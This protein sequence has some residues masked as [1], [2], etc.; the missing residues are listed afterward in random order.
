MAGADRAFDGGRASSVLAG[1]DN[2]SQRAAGD[3]PGTLASVKQPVAVPRL[4]EKEVWNG[5]DHAVAPSV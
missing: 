2:R 1:E 3:F 4:P 5:H